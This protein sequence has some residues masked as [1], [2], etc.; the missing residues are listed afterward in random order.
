MKRRHGIDKSKANS[1]KSD[2]T[3]QTRNGRTCEETIENNV[4]PTIEL[5]AFEDALSPVRMDPNKGVRI[6]EGTSSTTQLSYLMPH[7]TY[8]TSNQEQ[9]TLLNTFYNLSTLQVL[10]SSSQVDIIDT[11]VHV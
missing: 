1:L 9:N 7:E 3:L 4:G 5:P 2:S 10:N 6:F 8:V 11:N